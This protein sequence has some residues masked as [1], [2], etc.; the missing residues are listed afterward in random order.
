MK[1]VLQINLREMSNL[2]KN[3]ERTSINFF[4]LSAL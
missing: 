4:Q 2:Q 1:F 3:R